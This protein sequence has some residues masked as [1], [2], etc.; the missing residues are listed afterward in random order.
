[1]TKTVCVISLSHLGKNP[2]TF[3]QFKSDSS[4]NTAVLPIIHRNR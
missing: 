3:T 4:N 1:M 2:M